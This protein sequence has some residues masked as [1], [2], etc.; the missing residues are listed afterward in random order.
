MGKNRQ[1]SIQEGYQDPTV[2][3]ETINDNNRHYLQH[4]HREYSNN[5]RNTSSDR[6][7]FAPQEEQT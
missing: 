3:E 4:I 5:E 1:T 6:Q 2:R 7:F